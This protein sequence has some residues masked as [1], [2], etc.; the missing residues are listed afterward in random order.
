[1]DRPI[2]VDL[3]DIVYQSEQTPLYIHFPFRA[4]REAVH[5]FLHADVGE[6]RF[7]DPQSPA[8]NALA[9]ITIDLGFHR[10]DQI[11]GLAL[12]LNRKI[13]AYSICL[14]QATCPQR[15]GSAI[16]RASM[17]EIIG[18]MAVDLVASMAGQ[19][20]PLRTTIHLFVWI[21]REVRNSEET[22]LGVW[23]L[24]AVDAVLETFLLG[25]ARIAC[26]V[27]DVGDVRI[28]LF[29]LADL[30]AVERVIVGIGG[31][32]FALKIG[33]IFSDGGDVFFAP[34]NIGLRFS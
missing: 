9:L 6:D 30:Q 5:A 24:P 7:N 21:E 27:L 1:M 32:L 13:A 29:I 33:F 28:E 8:I 15:T 31:Q 19:F 26:A 2:S 14:L 23:T 3:A 16:F 12:N 17:V 11:G 22:R 4:E 20:F 10:I 18:A 25:K 34:S